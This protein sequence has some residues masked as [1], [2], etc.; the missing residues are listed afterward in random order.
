MEEC[1][2]SNQEKEDRP[3][4]LSLVRCDATVMFSC[5]LSILVNSCQ[6]LSVLV[7]TCQYFLN[8]YKSLVKSLINNNK[9]YH[10]YYN[11][12]LSEHFT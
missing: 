7:S 6:F 4:V 3:A 5:F 9:M 12:K 11:K 2:I 1:L 10:F 8:Q